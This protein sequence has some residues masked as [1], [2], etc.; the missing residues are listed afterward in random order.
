MA[1]PQV[2]IDVVRELRD[3]RQQRDAHGDGEQPDVPGRHLVAVGVP[4]S[5][6]VCGERCP[7]DR[8]AHRGEARSGPPAEKAQESQLRRTEGE[9]HPHRGVWVA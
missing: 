6:T 4:G 8:Q 7:E 3:E 1:V 2:A 9:E 5:S